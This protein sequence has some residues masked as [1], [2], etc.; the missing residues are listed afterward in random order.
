VVATASIAAAPTP[1][2]FAA[3]AQALLR[4]PGSSALARERALAFRWD[5]TVDGF[6]AVHGLTWAPTVAE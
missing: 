3:A 2:Q 6:L 4:R 5:A 1:A